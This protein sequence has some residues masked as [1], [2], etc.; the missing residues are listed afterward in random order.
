M[1]PGLTA[2]QQA[3][4]RYAHDNWKGD[5]LRF[6][7]ECLGV[8]LIPD[9]QQEALDLVG[10]MIDAKVALY[11]YNTSKLAP[12][13]AVDKKVK[14]AAKKFLDE[15]KLWP[16]AMK[17]GI[18]IRSGKGS[19]KDAFVSWLA[20]YFIIF[21]P[22]VKVP[23]IAPT[24]R[25]LET[26]LWS[27]IRKWHSRLNSKGKPMF[28]LHH[29]VS[30]EGKKVTHKFTQDEAMVWQLVA[31]KQGTAAKQQAALSGIHGD[32]LFPIYDEAPGIDEMNFQPIENTLTGM[33]NFAILIGNPNRRTGFFADT[34]LG[35]AAHQWVQL[36]WNTETSPLVTDEYI[37]RLKEK[38]GEGSNN[39]R[40]NVKGEFPIEESDAFIP[41]NWIDLATEERFTQDDWE[42]YDPIM[43]VDVALGGGDKCVVAIRQGPKIFPLIHIL[44][45]ESREIADKLLHIYYEH[46]AKALFIDNGG[47][48]HAV[49]TCLLDRGAHVRPIIAM[50][51]SSNPRCW[52]KRDE[53]WYNLR[54]ALENKEIELPK[55][56]DLIEQLTAIRS[57][58]SRFGGALKI[59]SK[60]DLRRRDVINSDSPDEA[61]AVTFCFAAPHTT[62]LRRSMDRFRDK[63]YNSLDRVVSPMSA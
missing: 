5:P 8:E 14:V 31:A 20:L 61:D 22:G 19:G 10:N 48:G 43:G 23:C 63:A 49:Y 38:Y 56:N 41:W 35:H 47:Q 37:Q 12:D 30:V 57:D 51:S 60:D 4:A 39:Y 16:L 7:R 26:V 46:N 11:Q 6:V 58:S 55:N 59:E 21:Y 17:N 36:H 40:V 29:L 53:C 44:E 2:K 54:C 34:H 28:R 3:F 25:S 52:R 50:G 62:Y 32:Y 27:E 18:S 33:C 15:Y 42:K 24:E 9:Y 45:T 13:A 1:P